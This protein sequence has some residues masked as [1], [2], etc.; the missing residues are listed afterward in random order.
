MGFATEVILRYTS[1]TNISVAIMPGPSRSEN[2]QARLMAFRYSLT[3]L[4]DFPALI[5]RAK[6]CMAVT[7]NSSAF[8]TDVLRLEISGPRQPHL[9]IV[10]LPGLIHSENKLQT[11]ADIQLVQN[12]VYEYMTNRRSIILA[13]ISAKNDYANQIVL[14]LARQ[15]DPHGRRTLGV[16]TKPDT[17]PVGSESELSF[18]NLARNMDIEFRLGWHVLKNRGYEV[19]RCSMEERDESEQQF[20]EQGVWKDL[21][22]D[23][24]GISTLRGKLSKIL[25]DQIKAEL[26]ALVEDIEGKIG[27]CRIIMAKLGSSRSTLNQQRLFI[28]QISQDF[29]AISK[30]AIDGSYGHQFFGDPR[31]ENGYPKRLRAVI[32]NLNVEFAETMRLRGQ[33]RRIVDGVVFCNT[34]RTTEPKIISRADFIDE[35]RDLLKITRGREL[36]GMF[37]PLIVGDLFY[38]QSRPWEALARQHVKNTWDAARLFI[39]L[40]LSD[41]TDE[42]TADVLFSN[43]IDPLLSQKFTQLNQKLDEILRP[44]QIGHP[45]T[46]N[47]YFIETIQKVKEKRQE[48]DI[49]NRLQKFLGHKDDSQSVNVKN[50]KIPSLLSA[51]TSRTEADMDRYACSEILDCMEAY[52]KVSISSRSEPC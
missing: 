3:Q 33:H 41:L 16:I 38:E 42:S 11:A 20:F 49:A 30:A 37:S 13:V 46:Y 6:D 35:I 10:D 14:K 28:L 45:I 32:Q 24:V 36:P 23:E 19:R 8:S 12:M 15:V 21:A 31:S 1:E 5:D 50:V 44:Y 4:E 51:L 39:D 40:L 27:D 52:Y 43:V 34:G 9:T 25:F 7:N 18:I 47:H 2:E 22:R 29:Q 48:E 26:R 17:L